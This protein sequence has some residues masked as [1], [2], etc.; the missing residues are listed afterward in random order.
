MVT[1]SNHADKVRLEV[2]AADLVNLVSNHSAQAG[3][4]TGWA[5]GPGVTLAASTNPTRSG[6]TLLGTYTGGRCIK[7]T[8][9]GA[10]TAASEVFG[11]T[12]SLSPGKVVGAVVSFAD[13]RAPS[14]SAPLRVEVVFQYFDVSS[15]SLGI[16]SAGLSDFLLG[17]D[18]PWRM[19]DTMAGY[20]STVPAAAV[21]GRVALRFTDNGVK[22]TRDVYVAKLMMVQA[23]SLHEAQNVPFGSVVWQ[24][25]IGAS[26]S[27]QIRRGGEVD[28]VVDNINEGSMTAVVVDPIMDPS[29]NPRMRVGRA[30]RVTAMDSTATWRPIFTGRI[31]SLDVQYADKRNPEAKPR[32]TLTAVDAIVELRKTNQPFGYAGAY[33]PKVKALM[34]ASSVPYVA[35]AG[36]ASTSIIHRDDQG[37]LWNQL[38]LARNSFVGAA[39]WVDCAGTLQ[40]RTLTDTGVAARTFTDE[41]ARTIVNQAANPTSESSGVV[42]V[43]SPS[44]AP[45]TTAQSSA[46]SKQGTYSTLVSKSDT[47]SASVI[48]VLEGASTSSNTIPVKLGDWLAFKV[49]IKAVVGLRVR[50]SLTQTPSTS[51]FPS[52]AVQTVDVAA[53]GTYSFD[54]AAEIT[55]PLSTLAK[56][57]LEVRGVSGGAI[58]ASG[59]I[60]HIDEWALYNMGPRPSSPVPFYATSGPFPVATTPYVDVDVSYGS[61]VLC[62]ELMVTL[63]NS[64]EVDGAKQYGPY[65]NAASRTDWGVES[66][67][68][69]ALDGS[70]SSLAGALLALY[71]VPTRFPRSAGFRWVD[72]Y[73]D[74][75]FTDLYDEVGIIHT[76]SGTDRVVR[77]LSV[78]HSITPRR[79]DVSLGFRPEGSSSITVTNPSA[80][81]DTGPEDVAG[82]PSG[83]C[84]GSRDLA[85]NRTIPNSAWTAVQ[86]DSAVEETNITWDGTNCWYEVPYNGRYLIVGQ[87]TFDPDATTNRMGASIY[88]NGSLIAQ[89]LHPFGSAAQY[90][91]AGLVEIVRLS[92]SDTVQL[93]AFQNSGVSRDLYE[94]AST[95]A[96]FLRVTYLGV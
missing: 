41:P 1:Q 20:V 21:T 68:V 92:K 82:V 10:A 4:T 72:G 55:D 50:A 17:D 25:V 56:I 37:K 36:S 8:Y 81:A 75:V 3:V 90:Q 60:V 22:I 96:T 73:G 78:E 77:V 93:R 88:V 42:P 35:D 23:D 48:N 30:V 45:V 31:G 14:T 27:V 47:S 44:G 16:W 6:E 2:D 28:G 38:L 24:N 39:A 87:V 52:S 66:A 59:G 13:S 65:V 26:T 7:A 33:G 91:S 80:G 51:G 19:H 95:P 89:R 61:G 86:L 69:Q 5:G 53:G 15:A 58:T 74:A 63:N 64:G 18:S 40:A 9:G 11:P 62:N 49:T 57:T 85:T 43:F 94:S 76:P 70:P 29:Q 34:A 67:E 32:V 71:A 46:W 79:W 54:L 84:F 83:S 12:V